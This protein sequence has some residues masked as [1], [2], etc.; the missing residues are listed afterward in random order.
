LIEDRGP[1]RVITINRPQVLNA[2]SRE[3]VGELS[4]AVHA[5]A[6]DVRS[7]LRGI[8]PDRRGRARPS[9]PGPTSRRCAR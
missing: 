3:V 1:V 8:D 7:G 4:E 9:S 5:A 2:L 6:R